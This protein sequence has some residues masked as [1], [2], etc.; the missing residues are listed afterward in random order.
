[1]FKEKDRVRHI[2]TGYEG[3]V[4]Q[5]YG[6]GEILVDYDNKSVLPCKLMAT[7]YELIRSIDVC[8]GCGN[9]WTEV[10]LF[11]STAYDCLTCNRKKEDI[12]AT[13]SQTPASKL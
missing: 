10:P 8:P 9:E 2:Y 3:S 11:N 5:V 4:T 13:T 12:D 1:M 7:E 6:S